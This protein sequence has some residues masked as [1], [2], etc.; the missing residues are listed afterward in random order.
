MMAPQIM[1]GGIYNEDLKG[2][3]VTHVIEKYEDHLKLNLS[4]N[5]VIEKLKLLDLN[6]ICVF[7]YFYVW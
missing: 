6:F 2:L 1:V 7:H 5:S 4:L 3:L